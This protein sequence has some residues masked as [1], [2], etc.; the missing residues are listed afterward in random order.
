M[1]NNLKTSL[2]I[3]IKTC[4]KNVH[5]ASLNQIFQRRQVENNFATT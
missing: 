3:S 2:K 4:E 5:K 1:R